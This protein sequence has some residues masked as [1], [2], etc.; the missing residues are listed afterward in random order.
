MP[1]ILSVSRIGWSKAKGKAV[2]WVFHWNGS[3][4]GTPL[5]NLFLVVPVPP[6][7]QIL[8]GPGS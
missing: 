5:R 4:I 7:T 1:V 2:N 8:P 6:D 3:S